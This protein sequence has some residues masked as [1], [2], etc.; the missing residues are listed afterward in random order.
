MLGLTAAGDD[1]GT[2]SPPGPNRSFPFAPMFH[3]A[4]FLRD[5]VRFMI[6]AR[7]RYGDV[8]VG[9]GDQVELVHFVGGG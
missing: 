5:P 6:E 9:D 1:A 8:P 7:S 3:W 4:R 2:K